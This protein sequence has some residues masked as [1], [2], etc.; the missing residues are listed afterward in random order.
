MSAAAFDRRQ[1]VTWTVLVAATVLS[2]AV[3]AHHQAT[4]AVHA[5]AAV[6]LAVALLKAR[7]VGREFMEVRGAP[8]ALRRVLDGWCLAVGGALVVL[9]LAV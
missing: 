7:W 3:G 4:G 8:L 9:Y 1:L 2:W 6:A 5:G